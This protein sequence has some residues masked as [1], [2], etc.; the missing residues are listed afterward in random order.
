MKSPLRIFS[1]LV[2]L[3]LCTVQS[4]AQVTLENTYSSMKTLRFV[5]FTAS[6]Q[7]YMYEA[8][9]QTLKLYNL[10]HTLWK[11]IVLPVPVGYN[12]ISVYNATDHLFNSDN[13]V[14]VTYSLG[15]PG[16]DSLFTRTVNEAGVM[17]LSVS[18]LPTVFRTTQGYKLVC[19]SSNA[20]YNTFWVYGL[21][22]DLPC[23]ECSPVGTLLNGAVESPSVLLSLY[24][25]PSGDILRV[26]YHL[27]S[28][29]TFASLS[30]YASDGRLVQKES[31]NQNSGITQFDV[32]QLSNGL[33]YLILQLPNGEQTV[34]EAVVN[35]N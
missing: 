19:S 30:M 22:G 28:F 4:S 27:P 15:I 17:V 23:K 14:E 24:P 29:C 7:K 5:E 12:F 32:T 10:D 16:T 2:G 11:T 26:S 20:A 6:G 1:A 31:I 3:V 8:S 13:L 21:P 18:G 9:G 25:S 34:R 33:Y 35:R